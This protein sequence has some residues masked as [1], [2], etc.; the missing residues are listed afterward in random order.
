MKL[1]SL[2]TPLPCL[3]PSDPAAPASKE[4]VSFDEMC[5]NV[6]DFDSG[7]AAR[8]AQRKVGSMIF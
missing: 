3:C 8:V 1:A 4:F 5:S 2:L 7:M 6:E